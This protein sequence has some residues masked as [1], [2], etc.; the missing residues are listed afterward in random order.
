MKNP[1][2]LFAV[3]V[4]LS[5]CAVPE[6]LIAT[7]GGTTVPQGVA[8]P[9]EFISVEPS[10]SPWYEKETGSGLK[11]IFWEEITNAQA[12]A[13]LPIERS[14]VSVKKVTADGTV[15]FTSAKF[16]AEAGNY[17]TILDYAKFRDERMG[18]N[19]IPVRVG[20]GVRI[21]ANITTT[22]AN[23]D[24]GSLFAIAFAAKAGY[25][26]GQIEVIK[27]GIDSS[28]LNMVLP[29]PTEI[30]DT[31]LQNSLQAVAAIR[32]KLYDTDT[33]LRPHIIAVRWKSP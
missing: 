21:V 4:L 22:K 18:T 30:N 2:S 26:S 6:T 14:F 29:P 27:I 33:R 15:G 28:Q 1:L 25:L 9:L 24:L 31:S 19:Q 11:K 23:V 10:A 12:N 32:S 17:R 13:D 16:T 5:A 7:P 3:A 20:V 8:V